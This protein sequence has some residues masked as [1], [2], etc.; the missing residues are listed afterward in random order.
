MPVFVK[1]SKAS[2]FHTVIAAFN[3]VRIHSETVCLLALAAFST[4]WRSS[5]LKRTC[6][7]V[8]FASPLGSFGR[9]T[10]LGLGWVGISVLLH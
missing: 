9:P 10:F 4:R 5:G 6:T 3:V 7:G 1:A 2:D 8:P